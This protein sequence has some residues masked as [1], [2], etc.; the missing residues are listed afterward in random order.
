MKDDPLLE[1]ADSLVPMANI[2]AVDLYVP[3]LD[4]FP[5]LRSVDVKH[6]EFI[7]TIAGI[8]IATTRLHNLRSGDIREQR[9]MDRV[10][11]R[12]DQWNSNGLNGFEHCKSFFERTFDA[13]LTAEHEPRFI[14]SDT[15]RSWIVWD[16]LDRAPSAEEER[17]LVRTI[18]VAITHAFF[19]WWKEDGG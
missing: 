16:V 8:F 2:C 10:A 6:W 4:Q 15:I 13:L 7:V 17:R 11:E 14:A 9:L 18:G 19:D 5:F 1:R 12:L 3:M